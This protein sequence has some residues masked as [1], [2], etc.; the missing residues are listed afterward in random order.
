MSSMRERWRDVIDPRTSLQ[1]EH[2]LRNGVIVIGIVAL[3]VYMAVAHDIPVINGKPGY[4]VRAEFASVNQL[5][6]NTPV[7]VNGVDVGIVDKI[8]AGDDPQR[9]S[10]VTLRITD[11]DLEVKRDARA[12]IRWRT[13]LG[14][15]MFVDLQPGSARTPEIG[16][17]EIPLKATGNQTELDDVLQVYDGG[18]EQAQ[19]DALKGLD[20]GFADP[21]ATRGAIDRLPDLKTVERGLPPY[22]GTESGDLRK[23]VAATAATVESLGESPAELQRL[24]SGAQQTLRATAAE[25]AALGRFL[26]QSPP[27]LDSTLVT[28]RRIRTTLEHLDPLVDAVRPG[29]RRIAAATD[30]ATPALRQARALLDEVQPLLGDLR[31]AFSDL[32]TVG[33]TGTPIIDELEPTVDRANE[34]LLPWLERTDKTTKVRNST[35]IGA[36]FSVLS[37]AAAEFDAIGHRLHLST[38]A[39]SNSVISLAFAQNKARCLS[40]AKTAAQREACPSLAR[41]LAYSVLGPKKGGGK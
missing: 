25:R 2:P 1:R 21:Q 29:V 36:T 41:A 18:T 6:T 26:Q 12:E 10:E 15:R 34:V 9:S 28:M 3:A 40:V 32:A 33:R 39:A 17:G 13:V 14:G 8:E 24:V 23:L 38:P 27:S 19:R 35:S 4:T 37:M 31:P 5:S 20:Q 7:R 30:A 11:E 22:L 16:G